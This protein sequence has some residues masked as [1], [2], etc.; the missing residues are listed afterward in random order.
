V[1]V[2]RGTLLRLA[3][4]PEWGLIYAPPLVNKHIKS[5]ESKDYLYTLPLSDK[6][7]FRA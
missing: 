3:P 7:Y 1:A 5:G 4:H 6:Y 2:K